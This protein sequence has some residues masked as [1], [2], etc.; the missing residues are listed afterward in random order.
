V[1]TPDPDRYGD[2]KARGKMASGPQLGDPDGRRVRPVEPDPGVTFA[3]GA[4][5]SIAPVLRDTAT[6][7]EEDAPDPYG[8]EGDQTGEDVYSG[9]A[10][11]L[12]QR[13]QTLPDGQPSG[14]L[15]Y[16]DEA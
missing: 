6:R 1:T 11:I 8:P 10:E 3:T 12:R 15:I 4:N 9:A 14:K 13:Y 7:R 2:R 16:T 5:A